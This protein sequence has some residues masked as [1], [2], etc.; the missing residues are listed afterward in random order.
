[1]EKLYHDVQPSDGM[2]PQVPF[3][4]KDTTRALNIDAPMQVVAALCGRHAIG[5]SM[6][7]PLQSGGTRIV[8]NTS[9][10]ADGIRRRMKGKLIEGPVIRSGLHIGRR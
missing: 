2:S 5:I 6:I 1:M 10:G 8:L 7:E 3:D 9:E 4:A